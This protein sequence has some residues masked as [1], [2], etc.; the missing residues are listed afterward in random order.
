MFRF[1]FLWTY[2][3]WYTKVVLEEQG[4]N[5]QEISRKRASVVGA[6]PT[7]RE[8]AMTA[9]DGKLVGGLAADET[10]RRRRGSLRQACANKVGTR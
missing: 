6:A 3:R 9:R 1:K 7:E 8:K 5:T 10:N 4:D 2:L